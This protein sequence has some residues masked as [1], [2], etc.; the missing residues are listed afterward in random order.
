MSIMVLGIDPSLTKTALCWGDGSHPRGEHVL[1]ES[2]AAGNELAARRQRYNT[3]LGRVAEVLDSLVVPI[4]VVF[5]EGYSY[6]SGDKGTFLGEFGIK[7]RELLI[8]RYADMVFELPPKIVKKFI[9]GTGNAGKELMVSAVA[10]KWG[11]LTGRGQ[12]FETNDEV[13]AFAHWQYGLSAVGAVKTTAEQRT[14]FRK[15]LGFERLPFWDQREREHA[16]GTNLPGD[17]STNADARPG[18][19]PGGKDEGAAGR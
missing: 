12:D 18:D 2:A 15:Q 17:G 5:L 14:Q 4:D 1:F 16:G 11:F 6:A 13:D 8:D 9:A 10:K 3:V 7:I 19:K